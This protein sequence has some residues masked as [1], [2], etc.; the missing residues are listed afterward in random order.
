M[1]FDIYVLVPAGSWPTAR[2]LD[3]A[4]VSMGYPVRLG[5]R[6]PSAWEAPLA[7]VAA[8]PI[9]FIVENADQAKALGQPVG[10]QVEMPTELAMPVVLDGV[11]LDP[12]FGMEAVTDAEAFNARL[13]DFADGPSAETGDYLVWFSHHADQRN[14]NAAMYVLSALILK[15]NGHGFEPQGMSHGRKAFAR[16][17]MD[18]L[19]P[20]PI[21]NPFD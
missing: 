5:A 8:E 15:F 21:E 16:E 11:M 7:P 20:H 13:S 4:L 19:Y 3:D 18:S 6:S 9:R 14:Y 1:S 2:E 12:D 17:L 10:A